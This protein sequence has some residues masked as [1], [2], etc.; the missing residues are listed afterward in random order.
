[1][2]VAIG[3]A[4]APT[5]VSAF[6]IDTHVWI[7][8]QVLNDVVPDGKVTIEPFGE[9]TVAPDLVASLRAYPSAYRMGAVGPD[10]FP[11]LVGGQMT[12]HPGVR[13]NWQTDDWL[14]WV[15]SHAGTAIPIPSRI[16]SST[17][18]VISGYYGNESQAFA[19]G[20]LTHAASDIFAH[21]YINTYA[22]DI[23]LLGDHEQEV[24]FRHMALEGFIKL[25]NP[26]FLDQ[27][28]ND[29]GR[30]ED[31]VSSPTGFIR[32]ALIL[33]GTVAG[34]YSAPGA[35][36]EH[37]TAMYRLWKRQQD[38]LDNIDAAVRTTN[39]KIQDLQDRIT[40]LTST[41]VC[42]PFLGCA[43]VYPA[44]CFLDPGTCIAV[45]GINK[46]LDVLQKANEGVG[47]SLKKP[48]SD[49]HDQTLDAITDYVNTSEK[50]VKELMK[51]GGDPTARLREWVTCKA[52]VLTG[53]NANIAT[54]SCVPLNK[55]A[56]AIDYVKSLCDK[57]DDVFGIF[58]WGVAPQC[59]IHEQI[60][61]ELKNGAG[62]DFSAALLGDD[63]LMTSLVRLRTEDP[64]ATKLD[65]E[66]TTDS[67]S[68]HLLQIVDLAGHINVAARAAAEMHVTDGHFDPNRF[69][70]V[71][72][73]IV[74]SKLV[75]LPPGELNRLADAAGVGTTVYGAD[76]YS[77]T[78]S[79]TVGSNDTIGSN[80]LFGAVRSIDGNQ[81]W[82]EAATPYP[83]QAPVA[84]ERNKTDANY[85]YG[86]AFN[87]TL[88]TGFRFWQDCEARSKVF[89]RIFTG[90]LVAG[91]GGP[92]DLGLSDALP[93]GDPN[94]TPT[95]TA[96]GYDAS[97]TIVTLASGDG[98]QLPPPPF[99]A[100]WW[101]ATDY[102]RP[103][104]DPT[105]EVIQVTA[106]TGDVLTVER[107]Q[108]TT[109]A[110][111][112][113]AAGRTYKVTAGPFLMSPDSRNVTKFEDGKF[114]CG[115]RPQVILPIGD[116]TRRGPDITAPTI[117]A[118]AAITAQCLAGAARDLDL[119]TPVVTDDR[120]PEPIIENDA[121]DV[122][123]YGTTVVRW[124]AT[125]H[126]NN[127][128][129]ADQTVSV[130]DTTRPT[131][132]TVPPAITLTANN[133][134]GMTPILTPPTATDSC[135]GPVHVAL[136]RPIGRVPIGVNVV[137]WKAQDR[138]GNAAFAS[139]T[140]TVRA[141]RGD[142]DVDGDVDSDDLNILLN[143]RNTPAIGTTTL[144][145]YNRD[146]VIDDLDRATYD[147]IRAGNSDPRDLNRDGVIDVLDAR[148][149]VTLC[150][151]AKCATR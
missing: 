117:K 91:L 25:H 37:L 52:P 3:L 73:A 51:P 14:K 144:Q 49:W 132:V 134:L 46:A 69:D 68:K 9:F 31:L 88:G 45:A 61:T 17:V 34:Q 1:V 19:Y 114:V 8:Q 63:S 70:P 151:R 33:N 11:D 115:E 82:Q 125:D 150:T 27:N 92:R 147:L 80:V 5:F 104:D 128:A 101:N 140:I 145:D 55:V 32:N 36:S 130:V 23:F 12:T 126:S 142:L 89:G 47:A 107:G 30:P 83:R 67:S 111:A 96:T 44:S 24:E 75:L 103:A 43:T 60:E 50:V 64:D 28:G 71:H 105:A 77:P 120:D 133:P 121:P 93:G 102:S 141:M 29:L 20:Y 113:N 79:F 124:T 110:S 62:T 109:T 149:L 65:G 76:M 38:A 90:P 116:R 7:A 18:N 66:F 148:V 119:G 84:A 15:V 13:D 108:E 98:A 118:P 26:P 10:G 95:V 146:G 53:V 99:R 22:G 57:V 6:K 122:F 87:A 21:S 139:Q 78:T 16:P 35:L 94:R 138:A 81:Q 72:N 39:D 135:D 41:E 2:I 74:L 112:K 85:P 48:I 40:D 136:T 58:T 97:A 123:S 100:T 56:D 129:A 131:F 42:V 59:A 143:S 127:S 54:A 4:V 137:T 106:V 86:Y